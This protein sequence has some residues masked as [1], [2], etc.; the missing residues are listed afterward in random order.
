MNHLL[1]VADDKKIH[2]IPNNL[3]SL[4]LS[5]NTSNGHKFP[6]TKNNIFIWVSS[7]AVS[8][9]SA[10]NTHSL[11]AL[12]ESLS[13]VYLLSSFLSPKEFTAL[14]SV[15]GIQP[16]CASETVAWLSVQYLFFPKSEYSPCFVGQ[17]YLPI[18]PTY[19]IFFN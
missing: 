18:C 7:F 9:V 11:Y 17:L 12:D 14:I 13:A 2:G 15:D 1:P 4:L 19:W 6:S 8:E 16:T 5:F 10:H 3:S